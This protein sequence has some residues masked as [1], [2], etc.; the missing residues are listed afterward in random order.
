MSNQL[1]KSMM[2]SPNSILSAV[3]SLKQNPMQFIMQRKFNVP[4]NIMNDPNAIIQHLMNTGQV[5]QQ[6]YNNAVRKIGQL[7]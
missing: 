3:Q 1:Y 4:Q 2:N 6:S 5:S 7:K